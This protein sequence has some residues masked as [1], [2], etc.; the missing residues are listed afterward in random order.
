MSRLTRR[1]K[2]RGRRS[3]AVRLDRWAGHAL[4]GEELITI[5]SPENR[6]FRTPPNKSLDASGGSVFRN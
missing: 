1:C 2:G 4:V 3:S 6:P 5:V